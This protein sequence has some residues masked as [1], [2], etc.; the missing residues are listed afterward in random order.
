[1]GSKSVGLLRGRGG[2]SEYWAAV[3]LCYAAVF[4]L[5]LMGINLRYAVTVVLLRFQIRRFH[6]IGRSGWWALV[7]Q[8][9]PLGEYGAVLQLGGRTAQASALGLAVAL[10]LGFVFTIW[11]GAMPGEDGANAYGP[12]PSTRRTAKQMDEVFG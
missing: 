3:G 6:D 1:M 8:V 10:L 12:P 7:A 5:A 11:L 2:R 9:V 4:V